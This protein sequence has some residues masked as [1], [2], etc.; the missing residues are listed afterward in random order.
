MLDTSAS[1]ALRTKGTQ[2]HRAAVRY[3]TEA[4]HRG[5][6]FVLA[7]VVF[8]ETMNLVRQRL[9]TLASIQTGRR[10]R[11][12][13]ED[14]EALRGWLA[15]GVPYGPRDL[16][17]TEL[18]ATPDDVLVSATNQTVQ[19]RVMASLSLDGELVFML[20]KAAEAD[21][22]RVCGLPLVRAYHWRPS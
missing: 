19:V 6:R 13:S 11:R 18:E 22:H 12:G 1:Y 9:G 2:Q 15:A 3:A 7:D 16:H 17:V 21:D 14:S 20:L 8:L 4:S 10:L 5:I